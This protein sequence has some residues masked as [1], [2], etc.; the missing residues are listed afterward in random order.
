MKKI[1]KKISTA[2]KDGENVAIRYKNIEDYIDLET[3][4]EKIFL[5][6]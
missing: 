4:H 1:K 2:L 3:G 6:H 5:K